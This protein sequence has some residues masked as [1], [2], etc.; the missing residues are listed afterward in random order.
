MTCSDEGMLNCKK[1][2]EDIKVGDGNLIK[3]TK[4]GSK[5]VCV[6]QLGG[7]IKE[8]VI[9]E[10]KYVPKSHQPCVKDRSS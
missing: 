9:T 4:K 1:I 8:F 7:I 5:P 6:L 2:N 10:F 3:A